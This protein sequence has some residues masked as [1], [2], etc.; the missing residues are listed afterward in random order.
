MDRDE[1]LKIVESICV[2]FKGTLQD[3]Q[4]IQK[5]LEVLKQEKKAVYVEDVAETVE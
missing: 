4:V 3:H 1:A 5:A 2:Q